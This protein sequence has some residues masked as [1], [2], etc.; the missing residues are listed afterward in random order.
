ME[1]VVEID[2]RMRRL[3]RVSQSWILQQSRDGAPQAKAGRVPEG[4]AAVV[5]LRKVIEEWP[6]GFPYEGSSG[7]LVSVVGMW[8]ARSDE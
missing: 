8:R 7:A 2:E 1:L 4:R 6:A 3:A 5:P